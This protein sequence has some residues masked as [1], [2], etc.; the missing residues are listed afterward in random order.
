[1]FLNF[2]H[3]F[4]ASQTSS[5]VGDFLLP[6]LALKNLRGTPPERQYAWCSS[7]NKKLCIAV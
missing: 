2:I 1:M 3:L 6:H 4:L 5:F 7:R